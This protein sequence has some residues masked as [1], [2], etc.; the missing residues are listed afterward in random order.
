MLILFTLTTLMYNL[1][2][3]PLLNNVGG[4]ST[5]EVKLA[6]NLAK[7]PLCWNHGQWS[8]YEKQIDSLVAIVSEVFFG[9]VALIVGFNCGRVSEAYYASAYTRHAEHVSLIIRDL[10]Y[11]YLYTPAMYPPG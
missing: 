4:S 3:A 11:A 6:L 9:Y 5:F 10:N 8:S 1:E 2:S 7:D